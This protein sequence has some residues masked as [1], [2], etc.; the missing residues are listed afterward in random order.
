MGPVG[1]RVVV[2]IGSLVKG[3]WFV[4]PP[5]TIIAWRNEGGKIDIRSAQDGRSGEV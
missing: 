4:R 3:T 5:T 2:H 1:Q